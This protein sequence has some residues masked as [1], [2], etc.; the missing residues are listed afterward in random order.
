[1]HA[2]S[3]EKESPLISLKEVSVIYK[4][5]ERALG[6]EK[7]LYA[8]DG[9]SLEV[10]KGENL[11]LVGESGC[12][13]TT[14]G[15]TIVGLIKP[16]SGIVFYKGKD[17]WKLRGDEWKNARRNLQIIHQN[18][19]DAVNFTKTIF[20]IL[21][22]PL[23]EHKLVN[24]ELE[25]KEKIYSLLEMVGLGREIAEKYPHQLSGGQLQRVIIARAISLT[26]ELIVADEPVSMIDVSLRIS[27]LDLLLSL[28]RKYNIATVFITHDLG[29]ARYYGRDGKIAIMY[30]GNI[31]EVGFIEKVIREPLHPYTEALLFAVPVPDPELAKKRGFPPLR[32]PEVTD[33]TIMLPGCKFYPRCIYARDIC[34]EKRP[35]LK[36]IDDRWVACHLLK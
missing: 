30:L 36:M 8:V 7:N 6:K 21:S 13:K 31:V 18:P 5:K 35:S 11:S 12:G 15:K 27:I 1:M 29:L 10:L 19:Y 24:S 33:P 25:L 28:R 22:V 16:S 4:V 32:S 34:K 2:I 3:T 9:V 14:L 23:K 26:P 20:Q 17:L